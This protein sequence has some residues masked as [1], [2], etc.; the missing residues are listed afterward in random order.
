[1]NDLLSSFTDE[2]RK[3]LNSW[4]PQ[5]SA[6]WWERYVLGVLTYQQQER[7][8][9]SRIVDLSGLDLAA[10]LRVLDQ[11]WFD[12]SARFNWPK[13]GRNW[14]KEAQTIRNRWAHAPSG[15]ADPHDTYRDAD[16]I[17][18]LAKMFVIRYAAQTQITLYKQQ[19]LAQIAPQPTPIPPQPSVVAPIVEIPPTPVPVVAA[20]VTQAS[21]NQDGYFP[22][23]LVR[24]KSNRDKLSS[25]HSVL[26]TS[27]RL[28]CCTNN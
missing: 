1:M 15:D 7:V 8:K 26:P 18:R 3:R 6:D 21:I 12:L 13:E 24:L 28:H 10:L 23:Q 16:T 25:I 14:L 22:G 9:Q 2:L 5:L 27:G 4:L 17:D 19:Q 11:N 20:I